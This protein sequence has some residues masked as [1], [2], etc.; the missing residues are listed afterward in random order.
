MIKTKWDG[1][2]YDEIEKACI[3]KGVDITKLENITVTNQANAQNLIFE[4]DVIVS[5][6]F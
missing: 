6:S 1:V 2:C 3:E 4:S 5:F